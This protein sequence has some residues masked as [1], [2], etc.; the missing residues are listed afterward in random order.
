[1]SEPIVFYASFPTNATAIRMH[2]D[3]GF[4]ITLDIAESESSV[5]AA[6]AQ[7]R[8]KTM[9]ITAQV[10]EQPVGKAEQTTKIVNWK[11]R[12]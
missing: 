7:M 1:M 3:G 4:R 6:L 10:E 2:G 12:R 8:G 11:E 9:I 5:M